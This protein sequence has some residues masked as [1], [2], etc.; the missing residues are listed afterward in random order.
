MSPT[1]LDQ[2]RTA[3]LINRAGVCAGDGNFAAALRYADAARRLCPSD[4]K[5]NALTARLLFV[6]GFA[7]ESALLL[8][9]IAPGRRDIDRDR[10]SIEL[11]LH[12]QDYESAAISA[13][14]M[15]AAYALDGIPEL[16]PLATAIC[17]A[18]P[19]AYSGWL[20]VDASGVLA[21][22]IRAD[23]GARLRRAAEISA[24]PIEW[25]DGASAPGF[26]RFRCGWHG[27]TP[28][29]L[30]QLVPAG[31]RLIGDRNTTWPPP[32]NFVGE[33]NLR[34]TTLEIRVSLDWA[35]DHPLTLILADDR[36]D[37]A[38][39]IV[40]RPGSAFGEEPDLA[41]DLASLGFRGTILTIEALLP[42]GRRRRLIGSPMRL[43][44]ASQS[45]ALPI[46][47][48]IPGRSAA[49]R[50]TGDRVTIIIPVHSG[51]DETLACLDSVACSVDSTA[52]EIVVIDDASPDPH[53]AAALDA[54]AS[55]GGCRLLRN[56]SNLG[57]PGAVNRGFEFR[58]EGD[59]VLLN[60]DAVVFG[61]WL[62]RLRRAA[63]SAPDIGTVTPFTNAGSIMSY[64]AG[65]ESAIDTDRARELDRLAGR[66]NRGL[67]AE[68]PTGVGFCL[69]IRGDCRAETGLFEAMAFD[70]GYG[71]ENDFCMRARRLGW[72]HVAAAD[73]FVQHIGGHSFG[74]LKPVLMARNGKIL[75][76]RHP[77]YD[78]LVEDFIE[79]DPLKPARRRLDEARV[80]ALGRPVVLLITLALTGGVARHVEERCAALDG[81]GFQPITLRPAK[82]EA[83]E[84]ICRLEIYRQ[85][86]GD[87]AY[88]LPVEFDHLV[89]LL[90]AIGPER[91]E[92]HHFLGLDPSIFDLP[93]RLGVPYEVRIHDH[94]WI[95]PRGTLMGG[96][97]R[98]CGEPEIEACESCVQA[99]GSL[100]EEKI[101]VADLRSRSFRIL[102]K[103][104]RIA[105]PSRDTS[106]RFVRY[107]PSL[108]IEVEPLEPIAARG[109]FVPPPLH[110]GRVR[111]ALIGAISEQ[112]GFAVLHACAKDAVARDLPIEFVVI[113]YSSDDPALLE[114]DRI[115]VVGPYKEPEIDHLLRR[116]ACQV[117]FFASLSPETWCYSLTPALK[118]GMPILAFDLGAPAERLAGLAG[119]RLL[120]LASEPS[121]IN[122]VLLELAGHPV[123]RSRPEPAAPS[124]PS[125]QAIDDRKSTM[126]AIPSEPAPSSNGDISQ[127]V[128]SAV[129]LLP[130]VEG[131]YMF[132]VKAGPPGIPT[133]NGLLLPALLI[134]RA[135]ESNSRG[136][137]E[138]LEG[139]NLT[140]S[141]LA[142]P[143]DAI[144]ARVS[145]GPCQ[146]V[147]T[148]VNLPGRP[149]LALEVRRLDQPPPD[150]SLVQPIAGGA[151]ALGPVPATALPP[152]EAVPGGQGLIR[153]E[154]AA[155]LQNQGDVSFREGVWAGAFKQQRRLEAFA[156]KPLAEIPL[157]AVEYKALTAT[158]FETPW[159]T[160]GAWCGS[161]GLGTGIQG[162]AIRLKSPFAAEYDCEYTGS[163][164]S[165]TI[166]PTVRNGAPCR[167]P[168]PNDLL[169]AMQVRI[170][171]K[172]VVPGGP[173]DMAP[174]GSGVP[175]PGIAADRQT[176]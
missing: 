49:A 93:A 80:V 6:S 175:A 96:N 21:G 37:E 5:L 148:T 7:A 74:R 50:H 99:H 43:D 163:F 48:P 29:D 62:Q 147:M 98:Y 27:A 9:G 112:K 162:F 91:V 42:F 38:R 111:V 129:Q 157:D 11:A 56:E 152:T 145:G 109:A 64:P 20:G 33:A 133:R 167:S 101:S 125:P 122:E 44:V 63:Y 104:A 119:T 85:D 107:F 83:S 57:Y 86:L 31:I 137:L 12:H 141:W 116:E 92:F 67:V 136:K 78:R 22:E 32:L 77:G 13:E 171:V 155:H 160:N 17:R 1:R 14:Q 26:L 68:L 166:P 69:Y 105:A 169:E 173:R 90:R 176:S 70:R 54:K 75:N 120:P 161:R 128:I 16:P 87:L 124:T 130:F 131:L 159:Q 88:A 30:A 146:L 115:F 65:R 127:E 170:A 158:G 4:Q 139:P 117:A 60:A 66:V 134:S 123:A 35:P 15:L 144:V 76:K 3:D 164:M 41:I 150:P 172:R 36:G 135:P 81:R 153:L 8:D 53:L 94:S 18:L 103:A 168:T 51:Y 46:P 59:V 25:R 106:A 24:R 73:V 95:C 156:V 118:S 165:G 79:A 151:A 174:P 23:A 154:I 55:T 45:T 84:G 138:L 39:R 113:G 34:G 61:D 47:V 100:L 19:D 102:E 72:R 58:P 28:K 89:G 52:A 140:S 126:S 142:R 2:E 40:D 97:L 143:G 114:T 149:A 10:L 132:S 71:E 82:L 108:R 110:A 121:Q